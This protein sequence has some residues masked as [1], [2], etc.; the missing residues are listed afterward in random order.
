VVPDLLC[1]GKG[2]TSGFPLSACVGTPRAM[3]AWGL[4]KGEALHTSTFLVRPFSR[5]S[6]HSGASVGRSVGRAG[7]GAG[8]RALWP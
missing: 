1:L 7:V 2:L 3:G 8:K 6:V 4:S 5:V